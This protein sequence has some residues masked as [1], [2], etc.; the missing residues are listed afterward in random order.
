MYTTVKC[1]CQLINGRWVPVGQVE[2][3]QGLYNALL[4]AQSGLNLNQIGNPD[5]TDRLVASLAN[6]LRK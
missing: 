3:L 1:E 6:F 5:E 4:L 2:A